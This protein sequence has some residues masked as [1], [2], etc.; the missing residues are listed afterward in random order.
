MLR[1]RPANPTTLVKASVNSSNVAAS[2]VRA[3]F[4][5]NAIFAQM[6]DKR[7]GRSSW[8]WPAFKPALGAQIGWR[9]HHAGSGMRR[10]IVRIETWVGAAL[11]VVDRTK[12]L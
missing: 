10:K 11:D 5:D 9:D 2:K 7:L 8:G 6:T 3:I 1:R 12:F 4:R